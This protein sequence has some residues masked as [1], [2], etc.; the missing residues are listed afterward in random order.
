MMKKR[1]LT[2]E[3][4]RKKLGVALALLYAKIAEDEMRTAHIQYAEALT[5][6]MDFKTKIKKVSKKYGR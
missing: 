2:N 3:Q 6:V 1:K 4:I 5:K